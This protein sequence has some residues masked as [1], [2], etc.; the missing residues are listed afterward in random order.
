MADF[1]DEEYKEM[2]CV[3][4]GLVSA[5]HALAPGHAFV[6]EQTI[7]PVLGDAATIGEARSEL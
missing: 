5:F 2:V 1:G 3:E 6:L 4:P 7:R